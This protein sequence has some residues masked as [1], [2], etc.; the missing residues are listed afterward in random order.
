VG[1]GP[2]E[3]VTIGFE[4]GKFDGSILEEL[5]KVVADGTI[6]LIDGVFVHKTGEHSFEIAEFSEDPDAQELVGIAARVDGLISEEDVDA[7]ADDLP[8]GSA[9]AV[10]VFEHTWIIPV[11]DAIANAGGTLLDTVRIP[12]PAVDALLD[13]LAEL[14]EEE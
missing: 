12:G 10:L 5:S 7:V 14:E 2:V 13:E 9:A 6:T 11:R 3:I 4:E 1:A 8:V